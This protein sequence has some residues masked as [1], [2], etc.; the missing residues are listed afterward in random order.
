MSAETPTRASGRG[1]WP[2]GLLL[3]AGL[4]WFGFSA[5]NDSLATY[6]HDFE[7]VRSQPDQLLQVPGRIDRNVAQQ[8]DQQGGW[9]TFTMLDVA[10]GTQTLPVKTRQVKPGNFDEASQVV[11]IGKY[12]DE[13]F[14]ASKILVKCPSKERA[15]MVG[16]GSAGTAK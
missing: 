12:H 1:R 5:F 15:K 10:T 14:E 9:F 13:F 7:Q 6:T 2:L 8:Y 4:G 16:E 11:C 3:I